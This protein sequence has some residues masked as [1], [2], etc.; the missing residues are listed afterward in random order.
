MQFQEFLSLICRT[1]LT[2]CILLDPINKDVKNVRHP[3][4]KPG[5]EKYGDA[6]LN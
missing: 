1:R 6:S 5:G 3:E 4:K 2:V